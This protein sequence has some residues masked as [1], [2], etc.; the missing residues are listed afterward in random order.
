LKCYIC[1]AGYE[2]T[3]SNTCIKITVPQCATD[4]ENLTNNFNDQHLVLV[5]RFFQYASL[6]Y[7]LYI[8]G[9]TQCASSDDILY[10]VSNTNDTNLKDTLCGRILNDSGTFSAT[11][12]TAWIANTP[13]LASL[14]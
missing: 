7:D 1:D 11:A 10:K 3:D 5:D 12:R 13:D 2:L 4:K 8:E 14:S 6:A 9:C